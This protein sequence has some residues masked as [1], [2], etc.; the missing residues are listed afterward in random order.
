MFEVEKIIFVPWDHEEIYG[1]ADG[2]LRFIDDKNV[3][4]NGYFDEYDEIYKKKLFATLDKNGI[5]LHK[6]KYTNGDPDRNWAYIN[7]LQTKDI[8]LLPHLSIEEDGQ[9]LGKFLK[10]F[11]E[12]ASK[13]RIIQIDVSAIVAENGTLN[14]ISWTIKK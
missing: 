5:V 4:I 14:C 10:L 7:Y 12:Y 2:M 8:L 13:N 11:P 6:L 9:A 1:H 3:V